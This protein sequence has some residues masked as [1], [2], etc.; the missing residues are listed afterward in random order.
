LSSPRMGF[1]KRSGTVDSPNAFLRVVNLLESSGV[2][3][4]MEP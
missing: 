3:L 4:R 2:P 1:H